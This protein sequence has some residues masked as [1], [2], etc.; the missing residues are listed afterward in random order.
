MHIIKTLYKIFGIALIVAIIAPIPYFAWRM[1]QPLRYKDF[2]GLN[3]YQYQDWISMEYK[4]NSDSNKFAKG[5]CQYGGNVFT[6]ALS[7]TLLPTQ[8]FF[9]ALG[10]LLGNKPDPAHGLDAITD[11]Y[12]VN[13]DYGT[14]NGWHSNVTVDTT[15]WNFLPKW[16]N[17]YE[18]LFWF[19]DGPQSISTR[20]CPIRTPVPSPDQYQAMKQANQQASVVK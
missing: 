3:Y 6:K 19:G 20:P 1:D 18:F 5:Q 15:I 16:W 9:Y 2:N 4:I 7:I 14:V 8:S 13:A 10:G 12:Y 17:A 11:D